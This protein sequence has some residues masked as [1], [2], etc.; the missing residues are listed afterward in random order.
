MSVDEQLVRTM[1]PEVAESF[2]EIKARISR[3]KS[4]HL[5]VAAYGEEHCFLYLLGATY[6]YE[7]ALADVRTGAVKS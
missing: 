3:T 7:M 1:I 6:G 4:W 5:L 2:N